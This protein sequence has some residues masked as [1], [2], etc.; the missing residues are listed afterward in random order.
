MFLTLEVTQ[1]HTPVI[2][3][4]LL[5]KPIFILT[6]FLAKLYIHIS[7]HSLGGESYS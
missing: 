1:C 7:M 6:L 2:S 5:H 4:P 3:L